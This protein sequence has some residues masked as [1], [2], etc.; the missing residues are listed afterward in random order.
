MFEQ[1][2]LA[3]NSRAYE[4]GILNTD[5]MVFSQDVMKACESTYLALK[6]EA[7]CFGKVYASGSI[8]FITP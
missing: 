3:L 6:D 4:Y 8:P 1:F 5:E 7:C 2:I